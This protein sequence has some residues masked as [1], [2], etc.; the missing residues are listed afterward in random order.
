MRCVTESGPYHLFVGVDVAARSVSVSWLPSHGRPT[1]ARTIPQTAAGYTD[2][3]QR[4]VALGVPAPAVL[5]VLEAT[6]TYWIA[7][8]TTLAQAGFAVAVI[9]PAQAHAFAKA[10]LKRSKTDA[11][12][13]QTLAQLAALLQPAPWTPPPAIYA[14]LQ[15]RLAERDA[16]VTLRTEVQNQ[17]HALLQQ[18]V[19]IP[20][21]RQ[22]M[23]QLIALFTQQ[24]AEVEQEI[25]RALQMDPAWAAA[26]ERLQTITGIGRLTAAWILV[27]TLNFTLCRTATEA[28]GYA[29]LAPNERQSGTSV[30][31]R[32]RIGHT[33]NPRLRRALYL[34]TLS[35]TQRNPVIKVFYD[36][37][38]AAGKPA[39]VA[40]CAAARKLLHIAWAVATKGRTFDPT[41]T[42]C[43]QG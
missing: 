1:A 35:A 42:I 8:A 19:V 29:G 36:R 38:R 27:T 26:A 28:V 6:G 23:E 13:A 33:G 17:R 10:L 39:K 11:I 25:A 31:G 14:E 12:D 2:L 34:A 15:Q 21:V 24:I 16:L 43:P 22:R 4:L 5:I 3:Q 30:R 40:R 9:N 20:A 32:A 37:L 41:Y 7:L 18:P